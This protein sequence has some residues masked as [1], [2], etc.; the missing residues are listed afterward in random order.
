M[1]LEFKPD[2]D[3]LAKINANMKQNNNKFQQLE[4]SRSKVEKT[5][6]QV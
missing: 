2:L 3:F 6:E 4:V 5:K 1:S